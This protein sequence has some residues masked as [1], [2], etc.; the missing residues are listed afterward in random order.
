ML[1]TTVPKELMLHQK[2]EEVD[3]V[4]SKIESHKLEFRIITKTLTFHCY[5]E[6]I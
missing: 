6:K 3:T 1:G 5:L 2:K 4:M